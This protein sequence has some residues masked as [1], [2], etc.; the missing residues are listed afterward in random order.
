MDPP[1]LRYV[2]EPEVAARA[3]SGWMPYGPTL[4]SLHPFVFVPPGW[5]NK[6]AFAQIMGG[7]L[8][9][10]LCGT[11]EYVGISEP[12]K[13]E[14]VARINHLMQDGYVLH[15]HAVFSNTHFHQ[16]MVPFERALFTLK[17][18]KMWGF[19]SVDHFMQE[20]EM[21]EFEDDS[22]EQ[23]ENPQENPDELKETPS[24]GPRRVPLEKEKDPHRYPTTEGPSEGPGRGY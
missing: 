10:L 22:P 20:E 15:G 3:K 14:F 1:P 24:T 4:N 21:E 12:T 16:A 2:L 13:E 18:L 17:A 7:G 23:E 8:S 5:G 6:Y 9:A 19:L 11:D